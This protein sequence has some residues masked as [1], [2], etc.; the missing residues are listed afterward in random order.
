MNNISVTRNDITLNYGLQKILKGDNKGKEY[1]CP[2]VSTT[3]WEQLA[4]WLGLA[5]VKTIVGNWIKQVHQKL[6]WDCI[7]EST[8][9][10]NLDKF[11]AK[12]KDLTAAGLKLKEIEDKIDELQEQLAMRI[13]SATP[14]DFA[15]P[16]WQAE[17][18]KLN[19]ESR[20]YRAMWEDRKRAPKK[21]IDVVASVAVE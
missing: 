1:P 12:A 20:G 14:A 13:H 16:V 3:E 2:N 8:G 9:E 6:Y 10:F 21:E 4:S 7:D 5:Q 19:D 18:N 17:T 11:L 15:N